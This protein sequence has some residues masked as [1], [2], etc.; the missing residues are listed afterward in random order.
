[1]AGSDAESRASVLEAKL[2]AIADIR[3]IATSR[4]RCVRESINRYF[5]ESTAP[6]K[7]SIAVRIVEWLLSRS[8][9]VRETR[10]CCDHCDGVHAGNVVAWADQVFA[11]RRRSPWVGANPGARSEKLQR[12]GRAGTRS[13]G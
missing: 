11:Q 9:R 2:E 5:G 8:T 1:M 13:S 3:R 7:R 4:G 6:Q 10:F 12:R